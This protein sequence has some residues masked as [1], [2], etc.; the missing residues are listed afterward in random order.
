MPGTDTDQAEIL[1]RDWRNLTGASGKYAL[2]WEHERDGVHVTETIVHERARDHIDSHFLY[3]INE[4]GETRLEAMT[5]R[6]SFLWSWPKMERFLSEAGFG[7][8]EVKEFAAA[9]GKHSHLILSFRQ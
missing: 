7:A 5:M 3:L 2:G 8:F 4:H 9:N 6:R 1:E